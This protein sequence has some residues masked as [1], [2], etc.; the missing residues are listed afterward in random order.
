MSMD[1][2]KKYG[3]VSRAFHW[4]MA[5]LIGWQALKVF[6]RIADGEHWIGQTLVPWHVSVG[7][8]LL[9]LVIIRIVWS[10]RQKERPQPAT[11]VAPL[12]RA[13]HMALYAGMA[14]MPVTGILMLVGIGY[15]LEVFGLQLIP[16]G[17]E[18]AW[19]AS[20]GSL[21][22]PIAWMLLALIAGHI[23]MALWHH[24]VKKDDTLRRMTG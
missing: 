13:G 22:S 9:V 5:A 7:T 18:I 8:L 1:S 21:H 3:V 6:D 15:G 24:F 11:N 14:L 12:V 19:M 23:V 17:E 4:G 16:A 2:T 20:V 10:R